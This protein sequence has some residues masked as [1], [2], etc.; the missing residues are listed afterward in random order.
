MEWISKEIN[1]F[2]KKV[3]TNIKLKSIQYY[4]THGTL[5]E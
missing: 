1:V 4:K 3:G 2:K 5:K